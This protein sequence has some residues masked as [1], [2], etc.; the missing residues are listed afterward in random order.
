MHNLIIT[1][2]LMRIWDSLFSDANRFDF[3]L[4]MCCSMIVYVRTRSCKLELCNAY[5]PM[6]YS[7]V[8][9]KL[10]AADFAEAVQLLQV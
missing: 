4:Y 6:L 1:A 10:I 9:E 5:L 8:R 2:E 7:S 3:L